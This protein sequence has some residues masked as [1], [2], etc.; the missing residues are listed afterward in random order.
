[1]K[2]PRRVRLESLRSWFQE[3]KKHLLVGFCFKTS[4]LLH[5]K[6]ASARS[7]LV[8]GLLLAR[9]GD[10]V[11]RLAGTRAQ[12]VQSPTV[13]C[14]VDVVLEEKLNKKTRLQSEGQ[15]EAI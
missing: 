3:E 4:V 12:A 10:A 15:Q 14:V 8:V 2:D 9:A 5:L 1:M 11:L 7:V 6:A 13:L